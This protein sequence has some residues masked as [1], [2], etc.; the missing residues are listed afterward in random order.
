MTL[1][2]SSSGRTRRQKSYRQDN[3]NAIYKRVLQKKQR[4]KTLSCQVKDE[5]SHW[6]RSL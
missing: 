4:I 5:Y 2:R 6:Y 3:K 1:D